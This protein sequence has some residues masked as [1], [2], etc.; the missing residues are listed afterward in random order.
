MA[1]TKVSS[2]LVK[3][4]AVTSAKIVDGGIAT[5]DI[6]TNAITSTKIAQ[7]SILTKHIDD[8]QVTTAQL[9]ADA[10]TAAKIADDA[11]S[12]EHLDVT[13]ITGLTEVTAATGDLLMVADIS[14]SNNLK[15]IPVSSILAGTLTNA[16]QTNITSLGTLTSLNVDTMTLNGSSI[17]GT[18]NLTLD[19]DGGQVDFKD[20]GTLKALIDFTGDNVE[21]QSRVTDG[22]L[23]FRGQDGSSFITALTLDMSDA[24]T[25]IFNHDIKTGNNGNINIPTASSG[26]ANL[27]FDGSNFTIVSN[28]SSA[29][30]KLQTNSEDTLTIA[31]NGNLTHHRGTATFAGTIS[32]GAITSSG[33]LH[34]GD[35]TDISMDASANG[36]IE[37]DGNGYQGAIALDGS[38][39]H[40]YH[41]SSSRDLVL[42]TNETARLTIGGTGGFNFHSNNLTSV[43]AIT[44]SGNLLV[45]GIAAVNKTAVASAVALTINSDASTTSSYGLEV[46][47]AT[48]NTRLLVDGVGNTTF[49]GSNN[50]VTARFTSDN[51]FRIGASGGTGQRLSINGHAQSNTISEANAWLVGEANGGDGIAIG[52]KQSSP[53][54]TWIQSCY[55]STLG[56]SNHYALSFNPLGGNVGIGQ[57]SP[58]TTLHIG[59]GA[60]HYVRIENAGSGDVSSGYQIYRGASTVGMNLYDNP[61]D[62]TTSLLCAGNFNINAGGAGADLQVLSNGKVIIYGNSADWNETTQGGGTGSLHLDPENATNDYGSAI[63]WGASDTSSG[64]NAQAGIYVRSDGA[65]GTKMYI[66]TTDSYASGSKTSIKIDHAGR[67][68]MP[69]QPAFQAYLTGGQSITTTETTVAFNIENFDTG[70]NHANGVF[71]A[72]V[73]GVYNFGVNILLYPFTTGVVNARFYTNSSA[74]TVV[75]HGASNNSHTGLTMTAN[76]VCAAGDQITF[77]ISGSGLTSTNVYGGQAYWHGHLVG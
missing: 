17:T 69:R 10:V 13:V 55:L 36:Q 40:V 30:L 67:V 45:N 12:E 35:G 47:N 11:I 24:G 2:S 62:N 74:G 75:Q 59:D 57:D 22:D 43:G 53:Y 42:G 51:L 54:A 73:A 72:P 16:A 6:A 77:R 41:N 76:I 14:D 7:N 26:N 28:S 58:S 20:N 33:N 25:A 1:L 29:N 37:A 65:Y 34:A 70:G 4:D 38:A 52:T 56:T 71:T 15:K 44:S 63:T 27:S 50:A 68:T 64:A 49:Y 60:S 23:L 61:T 18:S 19:A 48:S 21:I 3:D 32:S 31:A 9:G 46:C 5:A 66:S 8:G 39:M